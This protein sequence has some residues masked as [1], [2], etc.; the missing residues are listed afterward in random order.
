M[1][2]IRSRLLVL[3]L[4]GA[5]A[6]GAA[7]C[8][9]NHDHYR[10]YDRDRDRYDSRYDGRDRDVRSD[11]DWDRRDRDRDRDWNHRSD[12]DWDRRD[13]LEMLY[14]G[15]REE[16]VLASGVE[17]VRQ[18]SERSPAV[19]GIMDWLGAPSFG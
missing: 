6:A 3:G 11:R 12:R 9:Y 16:L 13:R 8:D 15:D 14:S 2:R 5:M 19:L 7:A 17:I 1:N 4:L 10:D 18:N